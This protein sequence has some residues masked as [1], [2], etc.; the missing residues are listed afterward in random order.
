MKAGPGAAQQ[1][2]S[3]KYIGNS[4]IRL[5]S[6][7]EQKRIVTILDEAFSAIDKAMANTEK[8]LAN[9]RE[10]FESIKADALFPVSI[11]ETEV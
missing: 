8:N 3:P 9:A 11:H 5:P 6:L 2:V 7:G 1:N 4:K 10:L